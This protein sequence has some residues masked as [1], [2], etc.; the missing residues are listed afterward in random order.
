VATLTIHHFERAAKRVGSQSGQGLVEMFIA[1]VMLAI[2]I[3]A[4]IA[5]LTAGAVSLQR[6][7]QKG[8]ALT[9]ADRQLELYRTFSYAGVKLV[10]TLPGGGTTYATAHSLDATIPPATACANGTFTP[11]P[12]CLVVDNTNGETASCPVTAACTPSQTVTGPDHRTYEI[13]TYITYYNPPSGGTGS[14][15]GGVAHG[16]KQVL[17]VVRDPTRSGVP[18]LARD[19]SIF[20]PL[21]VATT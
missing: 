21:T 19:S 12:P 17:V 1:L 11:I 10:H 2:A 15:P 6:S 13:D 8:T 18:I 7:D 16:A 20:Q 14:T 4:L 9:I 3:G 5:V